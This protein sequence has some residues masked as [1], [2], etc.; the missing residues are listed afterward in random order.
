[1]NNN[2]EDIKDFILKGKD[3]EKIVLSRAINLHTKHKVMVYKNK[4]VV[5]I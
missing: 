2:S 4:T 5:F 1:M 3:L